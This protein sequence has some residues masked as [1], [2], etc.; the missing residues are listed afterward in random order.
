M[1]IAARNQQTS[2]HFC[3]TPKEN[4]THESVASLVSSLTARFRRL[5]GLLVSLNQRV[6]AN[7]ASAPTVWVPWAR[8]VN[9]SDEPLGTLP[10]QKRPDENP[11]FC[12]A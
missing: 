4:L 6:N 5:R 7:Y 10:K 3:K 2:T 1:Y 8:E 9:D 12:F 11:A